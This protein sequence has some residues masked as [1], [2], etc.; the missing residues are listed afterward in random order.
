[1]RAVIILVCLLTAGTVAQSAK[2]QPETTTATW[3]GTFTA[4]V[5]RAKQFR[6]RWS[7]Q[8][9]KKNAGSGSWV[10]LND[11]HKIVAEGTWQAQKSA[12]TWRGTWRA[13]AKGGR[14]YSGSWIAELGSFK[15][16]SFED[17]LSYTLEQ[18]VAGSWQSGKLAGNWWLRG[19]KW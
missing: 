15:G 13:W 17:M 18:Q 14:Q 12:K 6:G 7:G 11:A 3:H 1:M 8:V 2:P 10:V 9:D 5:G 4:S 16:Q 19:T